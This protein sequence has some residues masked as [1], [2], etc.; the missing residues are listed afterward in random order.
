MKQFTSAIV[1]LVLTVSLGCG[2]NPEPPPLDEETEQEIVEE[3]QSI[4]A[5]EKAQP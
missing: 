1:L 4:D 2:S 5:A 3:D